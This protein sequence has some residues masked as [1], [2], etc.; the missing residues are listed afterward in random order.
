MG[1]RPLVGLADE[2]VEFRLGLLL[3]AAERHPLLFALEDALGVGY[4][5][6]I[7]NQ[8]P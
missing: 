1:R 7:E 3:R 8:A 4:I 2:F 5:A 6:E